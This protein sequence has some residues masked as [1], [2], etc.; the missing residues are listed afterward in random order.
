VLVSHTCCRLQFPPRL[1]TSQK[2]SS[3]SHHITLI[4]FWVSSFF[5]FCQELLGEVTCI[6]VVYYNPVCIGYLWELLYKMFKLFTYAGTKRI[7]F[8]TGVESWLLTKKSNYKTEKTTG[9]AIYPLSN[10]WSNFI[11]RHAYIGLVLTEIKHRARYCKAASK[12][13]L[14]GSYVEV[15]YY[16]L[17]WWS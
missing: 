6:R 9:C 8:F 10:M 3:V 4:H 16:Y 11:S 15:L 14:V 5:L 17:Q 12:H 13:Q 1:Q 2:Y 7:C